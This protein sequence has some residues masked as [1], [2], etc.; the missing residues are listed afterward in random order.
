MTGGVVLTRDGYKADVEPECPCAADAPWSVADA[1][2]AS[3]LA[4]GGE[5]VDP[6]RSLRFVIPS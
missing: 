6:H 4:G 2:G 1:H 3:Q 5:Q